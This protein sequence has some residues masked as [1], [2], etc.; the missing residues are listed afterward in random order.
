VTVT[1]RSDRSAGPATGGTAPETATE[2]RVGALLVGLTFLAAVLFRWRPGPTPVDHWVFALVPPEP[3]DSLWI[4]VTEL[5]TLP[6]LLGGS[7]VAALVVVGRDRWRALACL[8]APAL[9]VLLAEYVLKPVI[10]RRYS[11]VLTF[12]SGT[13][14]VVA[15][16]ATAVAVAAP[17]WLR[18]VVVVVGSVLV[19]LECIAVVALQWH[20]P[21]DAI[22]GVLLGVGTVL[23]VDG[24]RHRFAPRRAGAVGAR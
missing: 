11:G 16:V 14:T 21:T 2:A 15:A 1:G 12:P 13:T 10:A 20:F 5:R 24:L 3:K 8:V 22:G 9:A 23:L 19:V 18:P 7:L 4:R 17:R 6:V